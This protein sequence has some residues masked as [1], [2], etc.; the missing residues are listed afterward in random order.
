MR[1]PFAPAII[2]LN[3]RLAEA[4]EKSEPIA[5]PRPRGTNRPHTDAKVAEVRRLI[6]ETTL[7]YKEIGAKTGV[8]PSLACRWRRDRGWERPL[9]ASRST[10]LVPSERASAKLRRR[11][12]GYRLSA[13]A[14]RAVRELEAAPQVDP[15]KLADALELF[16]LAKLA[17][18]PRKRRVFAEAMKSAEGPPLFDVMPREVMRALRHAG[19]QTE[20]LTEQALIDFII[21]RAPPPERNLTRRER[22]EKWMRER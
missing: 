3:P 22:R 11:W 5:G 10:D 16:K 13:L 2:R 18:G 9:F 14:E 21:S 20:N 1:H 17:A 6:E 8:D 7:T 15:D 12:L 19:I 4:A